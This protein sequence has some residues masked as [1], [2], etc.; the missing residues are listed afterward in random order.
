MKRLVIFDLDGTLVDAY[1]A[2]ISSV[3]YTVRRLG[4][5][6]PS[7]TRIR[8]AVGWGQRYLLE[9]FVDSKDLKQALR[10]FRPHHLRALLRGVRWMPHARRVVKTL[11]RRG[12]RVAIAS[13]RPT[14]FTRQILRVL[15]AARLFDAV[16]CADKVRRG[17]PHP[18]ILNDIL[19]RL[20]VTK[21]GAVY[22]GDMPI[23]IEAG[24]RAGMDTVGIATGSSTLKEIRA[25]APTVVIRDLSGLVKV[26][27]LLK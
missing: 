25:A 24:R 23:D 2:L 5:P 14:R 17:K 8:R 11:K 16:R 7:A 21:A 6:A 13:N 12:V 3:V 19:R 20:G 10:V 26:L 9:S 22:V 27:T 15:A 18:Q 1:P 4:Y